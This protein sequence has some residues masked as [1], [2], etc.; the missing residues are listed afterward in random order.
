MFCQNCGNKMEQGAKF[1]PECGNGKE[2]TASTPAQQE[3]IQEKTKEKQIRLAIKIVSG[4]LCLLFFFPMQS[5]AW[6]AGSLNMSGWDIMMGIQFE[7]WEIRESTIFFVLG[8]SAIIVIMAILERSY[9]SIVILSILGIIVKI[10]W[11]LLIA[12]NSD[13]LDDWYSFITVFWWLHL[14]IYI[15]LIVLGAMGSK[16]EAPIIVNEARQ[17]KTCPVC[18]IE[19]SPI[20]KKCPECK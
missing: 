1:C 11:W 15:T 3:N 2:P 17:L 20:Y 9:E 12:G 10:G 19:Y 13:T 18:K 14:A 6:F 7:W 4:V 16:N 8:I 5:V